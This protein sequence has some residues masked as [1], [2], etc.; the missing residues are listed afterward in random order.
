M[1]TTDVVELED[2]GEGL[3]V[4]EGSKG[5]GKVMSIMGEAG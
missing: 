5:Y 2:V 4:L 3:A 1:L